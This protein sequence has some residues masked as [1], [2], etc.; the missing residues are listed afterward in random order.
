MII[1]FFD[2]LTNSSKETCDTLKIG[3]SASTCACIYTCNTCMYVQYI[4]TC[5]YLLIYLYYSSDLKLGHLSNEGTKPTCTCT[6][7][8]APLWNEDFALY[9]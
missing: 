7:N 8:E 9:M 5:M 1:L 3:M 6:C 2:I 4:H